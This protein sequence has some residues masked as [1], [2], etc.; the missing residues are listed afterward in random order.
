M[1]DSLSLLPAFLTLVVVRRPLH[2]LCPHSFAAVLYISHRLVHLLSWVVNLNV[3]DIDHFGLGR[4]CFFRK[5][6]VV[7]LAEVDLLAGLEGTALADEVPDGCGGS[8]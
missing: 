6:S 1:G 5:D 4:I 7:G 2:D 3:N 8:I